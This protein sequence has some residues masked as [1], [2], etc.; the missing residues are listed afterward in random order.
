MAHVL[1]LPEL[2]EIIT[3]YQDGLNKWTMELV[4]R[5]R[6][7]HLSTYQL[8]T[9]LL[10]DIA[11]FHELYPTWFTY[12]GYAGLEKLVAYRRAFRIPLLYY[13]LIHGNA[14]LV[15]YLEIKFDVPIKEKAWLLASIYGHVSITEY[16]FKHHAQ[17]YTIKV[18][19]NAALH[20]HVGMIKYL[21]QSGLA[22][23]PTIRNTA[24]SRG[25][26]QVLK[27]AHEN[28]LGEWDSSGVDAAA[29]GGYLEILKF[30]HA[31]NYDG[32]GPSTMNI[33]V[34]YGHIDVVQFLHIYRN[35]GCTADALIFAAKYGKISLVKFLDENRQERDLRRTLKAAIKHG[36]V[37]V[38]QYLLLRH[39]LEIDFKAAK[40]AASHY[41]QSEILS[42]LKSKA[43]DSCAIQ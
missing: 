8:T 5:L 42:M 31:H 19:D 23:A 25:H 17:S 9:F 16:L 4:N 14:H 30:L 37:D 11:P 38:V 3:E 33:A 1:F 22:I 32:F 20:N 27:Y 28:N 15:K 13:A 18:M 24:C 29:R 21:H 39:R 34:L 40:R 6:R 7:V 35:E 43:H 26:L 10:D 36:H 2:M 41:N 12:Y